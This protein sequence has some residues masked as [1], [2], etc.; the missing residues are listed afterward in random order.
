[1]PELPLLPCCSRTG[2]YFTLR[3][4]LG[5]LWP[6]LW[7][8]RPQERYTVVRFAI[9]CLTFQYI[10]SCFLGV[11]YCFGKCPVC[12]LPGTFF[13]G[14]CSAP[15]CPTPK[16]LSYRCHHCRLVLISHSSS[17]TAEPPSIEKPVSLRNYEI[18]TTGTRSHPRVSRLRRRV[19]SP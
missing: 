13:A 5:S 7:F 15:P 11:S 6:C 12:L 16:C 9:E 19:F 2:T 10:Q 14:P 4:A 8:A 18:T 17:L 1:M 3:R